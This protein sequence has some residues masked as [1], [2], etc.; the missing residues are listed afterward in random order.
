MNARYFATA[1]VLILGMT[2][3]AAQTH[4]LT[5]IVVIGSLQLSMII[6]AVITFSRSFSDGAE[7]GNQTARDAAP[8][9]A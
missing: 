8:D 5:W 9:G 3:V 6:G 7:T 1:L 2:I 4:F